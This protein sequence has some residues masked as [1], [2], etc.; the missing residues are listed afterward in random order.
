[1]TNCDIPCNPPDGESMVSTSLAY[2]TLA[3][4]RE[5]VEKRVWTQRRGHRHHSIL[6]RRSR[7]GPAANQRH[8]REATLNTGLPDLTFHPDSCGNIIKV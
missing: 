1:M 5:F 3:W 8:C 7:E 6:C 4:L 2:S